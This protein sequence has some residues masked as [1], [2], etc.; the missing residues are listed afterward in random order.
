[1]IA[2]FTRKLA[3]QASRR[4]PN[5]IRKVG[6]HARNVNRGSSLKQRNSARSEF[7]KQASAI[8][9]TIGAGH[10][11]TLYELINSVGQSAFRHNDRIGQLRHAKSLFWRSA[12]LSKNVV[13]VKRDTSAIAQ[14]PIKSF[15]QDLL[16]LEERHPTSEFLGIKP[17]NVLFR[18]EQ[19]LVP[20]G[21]ESFQNGSK[22][23][24][25]PKLLRNNPHEDRFVDTLRDSSDASDSSD[26]MGPRH[27]PS[28]IDAVTTLSETESKA[29]LSQYNVPI[30][31]EA[32]VHTPAEAAEAA[33]T[34][35]YPVVA[36]L[37]GAS[38]AHKTE[39]GLVKLNLG[40]ASAVTAAATELLAKSRPEDGDVHIL[41]AQQVS[42]IREL[43]AGVI[44]DPQFGP[45]V[46]MGVGGVLAEA[47]NDVAF[48][49]AP[50]TTN[51]AFELIEDLRSQALFAPL[52]GEPA[53]NQDQL[54]ALLVGLGQLAIDRPD[55][56]SIDVNPLIVCNG[57]PI[58]VD[59]LVEL[60]D[61]G[62]QPGASPA[63]SPAASSTAS[64]TAAHGVAQ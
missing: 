26:E 34:I 38:I 8:V 6:T 58:A 17:A 3:H 13:V 30:P 2:N 46:M 32:V 51:D 49:P 55:I 19:N 24:F 31:A 14:L 5:R 16:H 29:L 22:V 44:R 57:T 60:V 15:H 64:P 50:L 10:A 52:R 4:I 9:G 56:A 23:K 47:I 25:S 40:N 61:S 36:K 12:Q 37:G 33:E 11:A 41:I 7:G 21:T 54:A 48:R 1:M 28:T 45:C 53:I 35:G 27:L 59:G 63:L 20:F 39:R 18:H 42:G 43:I 62:D